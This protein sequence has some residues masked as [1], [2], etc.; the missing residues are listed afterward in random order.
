MGVTSIFIGLVL[1]AMVLSLMAKVTHPA[2]RAGPG[3]AALVSIVQSVILSSIRYVSPSEVDIVKS[4]PSAANS[5][6]GGS[7]RPAAR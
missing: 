6:A 2:A 7:S 3:V 1:A 5:Q 4:M